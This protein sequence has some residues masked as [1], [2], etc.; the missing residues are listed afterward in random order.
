MQPARRLPRRH[1]AKGIVASGRPWLL[2]PLALALA[3]LLGGCLFRQ[4]QG[5]DFATS[6]TILR[7]TWTGAVAEYPA[8]GASTP[9]TLDLIATYV[10]SST[11]TVE[12]T[13]VIGSED[14]MV[15]D[16]EVW[17]GTLHHWIAPQVPADM[18][19]WLE[20]DLSRDEE[21]LWHLSA[22]VDTEAPRVSGSLR[23]VGSVPPEYYEV[24]FTHSGP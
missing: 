13:F 7:G 2:V 11:Y 14:P 12:G 23:A 16:G 19:P 21:V 8:V 15:I 4:T 18:P 6:P 10:S 17:A 24:A 1:S 3:L 20:A 9:V 22:V 5:I